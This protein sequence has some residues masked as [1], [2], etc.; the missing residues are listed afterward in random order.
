MSDEEKKVDGVEDEEKKQDQPRVNV[1][2]NYANQWL[3]DTDDQVGG[4]TPSA[5]VM[6]LRAEVQNDMRLMVYDH[7]D[8]KE[9]IDMNGFV[10]NVINHENTVFGREVLNRENDASWISQMVTDICDQEGIRQE[11]FQ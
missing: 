2:H 6:R 5:E 7:V 1:L 8:A 11:W 10:D 3:Y 9:G 4:E